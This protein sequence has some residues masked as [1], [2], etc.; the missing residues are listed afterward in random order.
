VP[1]NATVA[2][3]SGVGPPLEA[4][5]LAAVEPNCLCLRQHIAEL[6]LVVSVEPN[7]FGPVLPQSTLRCAVLSSS[8]QYLVT[9]LILF[10][11]FFTLN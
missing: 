10:L 5:A 1:S 8:M 4:T 2:P 11:F 3:S 6:A 7:S 9:F